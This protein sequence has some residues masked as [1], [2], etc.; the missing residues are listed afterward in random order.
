MQLDMNMIL[1]AVGLVLTAA[2]LYNTI[3]T[4]RSQTDKQALQDCEKRC[5]EEISRVRT[6]LIAR[7][8]ANSATTA[9]CHSKIASLRLDF[10]RHAGTVLTRKE[11]DGVMESAM[12]P[13]TQHMQRVENFIE[14]ILRAGILSTQTRH[15]ERGTST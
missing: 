7:N 15:R 2:T 14:E 1:A 8:S 13:V 11:L 6:D 5:M 3:V 10:E 9:E 12:E 4:H